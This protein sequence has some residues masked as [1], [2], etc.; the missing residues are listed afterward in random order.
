VRWKRTGWV[1]ETFK[2]LIESDAGAFRVSEATATLLGRPARLQLSLDQATGKV[3]ATVSAEPT[4]EDVR[5]IVT[6]GPWDSWLEGRA[7]L[8][9]A[10]TGMGAPRV[11]AID[12][13]T[14]SKGLAW[15][16]PAPLGKPAGEE[17]PLRAR[18]TIRSGALAELE[19]DLDR[20]PESVAFSW[21]KAPA[22]GGPSAAV[23]LDARLSEVRAETWQDFLRP[24]SA[25]KEGADKE[26]AAGAAK[27]GAAGAV[28]GPPPR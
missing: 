16:L 1:A 27:D 19:L 13:K 24:I 7:P 23:T 12:L 18:A 9:L 4:V 26:G 3:T 25:E 11:W 6:R 17:A 10:V 2:G 8:E 15:K 5:S 22:P 14:T 28:K 20:K 21:R